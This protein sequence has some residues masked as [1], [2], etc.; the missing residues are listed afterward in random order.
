MN[1]NLRFKHFAINFSTILETFAT[2][3]VKYQGRWHINMISNF[4]W[5]LKPDIPKD[6][7]E[8]KRNPLDK[9]FKKKAVK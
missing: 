1:M 7:E 6:E 9:S 2:S 8:L 5:M 3:R 4:C